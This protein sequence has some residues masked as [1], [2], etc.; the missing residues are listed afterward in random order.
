VLPIVLAAIQVTGSTVAGHSQL[1]VRALDGFGYLLLLAGPVALL[2]RF[3]YPLSAFVVALASTTAYALANYPRGPFV[4]ALIVATF[5]AVRRA[6]RVVVWVLCAA[7]YC[8]WVWLAVLVPR[9]AGV[10]LVRPT[11]AN[12]LVVFAW[13]GVVLALAEMTRVRSAHFAEMSRARNEAAR[14][15]EEQSLRQASDERLRIARELHDVLGHHLSLI[16]VRAGVALHLLDSQPEQAREALAAIRQASAE[17]LREVRGVLTALQ[18]APRAPAPT[19]DDLPALVD[20]AERAGLPVTVTTVGGA[21]RLPAEVDRAAYRIAQEALTNV[22]RHAGAGASVAVT[23]SYLDDELVL[24]VAD[25]GVS[26]STVE[27]GNGIVGMRERAA[28]LGGSLTAE[29]PA[30]GGFTVE[31]HLPTGGD[32]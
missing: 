27:E 11:L 19:L 14:A 9:V 31:A 26:V 1:G 17:G 30:A 32:A 18:D 16:N 21:R 25:D 3:R 28:A 2:C 4:L 24:A 29:S 23:L 22:R 20:E 10:A 12:A 5:S 7:A 6:N 15:R 8:C 13:G